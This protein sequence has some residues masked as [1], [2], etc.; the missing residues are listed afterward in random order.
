[1]GTIVNVLLT[2]NLIYIGF[3]HFFATPFT[4]SMVKRVFVLKSYIVSSFRM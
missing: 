4:F 2:G 3:A 1:M